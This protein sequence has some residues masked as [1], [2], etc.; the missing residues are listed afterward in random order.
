LIGISETGGERS[1]VSA[2]VSTH[3]LEDA[4]RK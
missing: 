2:D 3:G 4:A 1:M